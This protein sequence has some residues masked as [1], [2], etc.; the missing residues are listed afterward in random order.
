MQ[1]LAG[2]LFGAAMCCYMPACADERDSL[3]FSAYPAQKIYKGKHASVLLDTRE[4]RNFRTRLRESMAYPVAFAGEYVVV[5]WGCGSS[6]GQGAVVNARTG[7]VVFLPGT[8]SGWMHD[9]PSIEYRID[10]RLMVLR[11]SI[12]EKEPH[13][14]H[15]Y[16][17]SGNHFK[18][19]RH[20]PFERYPDLQQKEPEK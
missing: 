8:F 19:I 20:I 5:A 16:R 12:N 18:L 11:G 9:S 15:F 17:L 14:V 13:G 10:S 6:C 7:Q 2:M 1:F 4:K 3:P